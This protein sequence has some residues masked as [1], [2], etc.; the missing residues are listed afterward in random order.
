MKEKIINKKI[1]FF[2]LDRDIVLKDIND[3]EIL[4]IDKIDDKYYS[5]LS[6]FLN[7]NPFS[8]EVMEFVNVIANN[9]EKKDLKIFYN[10]IRN[11]KI[12]EFDEKKYNH[13]KKEHSLAYYRSYD[14]TVYI[15]NKNCS[16]CIYHELF[17]M[18]ISIKYDK[19]L[20][21]G[22]EQTNLVTKKTFG[23]GINEG[24]TQL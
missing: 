6:I 11:L 14:I 5:F 4:P 1:M 20:F 24:Y 23:G 3:I 8:K 2:K 22:F 17:H 7:G 12:K 10:N 13:G 16:S 9:F 21:F 15:S 19:Y 18:S